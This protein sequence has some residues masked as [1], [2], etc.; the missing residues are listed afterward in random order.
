MGLTERVHAL[1][2]K[3]MSE[4]EKS[5]MPSPFAI[6][7]EEIASVTKIEKTKNA[8]KALGMK[9][10]PKFTFEKVFWVVAWLQFL[11]A[12]LMI[13]I[14]YLASVGLVWDAIAFT[15]LLISLIRS[16]NIVVVGAMIK[17]FSNLLDKYNEKE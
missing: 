8:A 17:F 2:M 12:T 14:E 11:S 3:L 13:A 7:T 9:E 5:I 4:E 10:S 1:E 6:K 16:F 15:N